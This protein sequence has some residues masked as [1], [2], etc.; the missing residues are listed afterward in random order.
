MTAIAA[1]KGDIAPRNIAV[2]SSARSPRHHDTNGTTAASR[3]RLGRI[4]SA[5]PAN[6]PATIG[7]DYGRTA[8]CQNTSVQKAAAGTSAIAHMD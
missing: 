3:T 8:P 5:I 1:T 4:I 2:C 6:T 7:Q